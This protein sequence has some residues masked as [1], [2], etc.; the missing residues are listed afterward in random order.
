MLVCSQKVREGLL[1]RYNADGLSSRNATWCMADFQFPH[2]RFT[3]VT[4]TLLFCSEI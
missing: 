4:Y 1:A 3:L 2:A